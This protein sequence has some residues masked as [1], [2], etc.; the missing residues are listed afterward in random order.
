MQKLDSSMPFPKDWV[1][2]FWATWCW[3]CG[4]MDKILE[5]MN[6]NLIYSVDVEKVPDAASKFRIMWVPTLVYFKDGM[7]V[8]IESWVKTA[9]EILNNI[10]ELWIE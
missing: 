7:P 3:P 8:K 9:D 4:Q 6:S 1:V 2:K 5:W 10:K